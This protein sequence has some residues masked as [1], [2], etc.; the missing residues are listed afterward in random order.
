[1]FGKKEM[2]TTGVV[3]QR[4]GNV[5]HQ[6][7]P[8]DATHFRV[9]DKETYLTTGPGLYWN[10]RPIPRGWIF[11]YPQSNPL[12]LSRNEGEPDASGVRPVTVGEPRGLWAEDVD[13]LV[14]GWILRL[15]DA[16]MR[17]PRQGFDWKLALLLGGGGL[18]AVGAAWY[19][20]FGGGL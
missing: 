14:N 13:N 15:C 7:V 3:L 11:V 1:M 10:P 12:P 9:A 5:H 2:P 8:P 6:S 18:A 16:A 20:I 19:F 17:A 4:T